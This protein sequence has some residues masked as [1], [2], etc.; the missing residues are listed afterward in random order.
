MCAPDCRQLRNALKFLSKPCQDIEKDGGGEGGGGAA[1]AGRAAGGAGQQKALT[2]AD[3]SEETE[4]IEDASEPPAPMP[5]PP[6]PAAAAAPSALD[7]A[8]LLQ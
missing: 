7:S 8:A 5:Q 3:Y 4:M 1:H 6:V 2:A